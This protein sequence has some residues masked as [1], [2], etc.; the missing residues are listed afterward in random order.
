MSIDGWR[1]N[2]EAV[3][4]YNGT[5][6]ENARPVPSVSCDVTY[7]ASLV[8][9]KFNMKGGLMPG[10][11]LSCPADAKQTQTPLGGHDPKPGPEKVPQ[12]KQESVLTIKNLQ[13]PKET[14]HPRKK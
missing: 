14:I 5:L 2:G 7:N 9:L 1:A 4:L 12:K 6:T 11:C 3:H 10:I 8:Q 13:N